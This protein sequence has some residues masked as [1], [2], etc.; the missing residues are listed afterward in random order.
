MYQILL[1][2]EDL[3]MFDVGTSLLQ[4]FYQIL[5]TRFEALE[6]HSTVDN[7]AYNKEH[8]IRL[9]PIDA[10]FFEILRFRVRPPKGRELPLQIMAIMKIAGSKVVLKINI[11]NS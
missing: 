10:C 3:I 7:A 11:F 4:Q 5:L 8:M 1:F 6:F 9:R 2:I